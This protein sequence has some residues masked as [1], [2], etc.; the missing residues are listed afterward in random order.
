MSKLW[1]LVVIS[2]MDGGERWGT[3]KVFRYKTD[4]VARDTEDQSQ[5]EYKAI[6]INNDDKSASYDKSKGLFTIRKENVLYEGDG[7]EETISFEEFRRRTHEKGLVGTFPQYHFE[8][9]R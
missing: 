4:E 9:M 7:P 6:F 5:F 8:T 1:S 3:I 2:F